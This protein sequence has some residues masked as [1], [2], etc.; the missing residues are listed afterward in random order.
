MGGKPIWR[1]SAGHQGQYSI[2]LTSLLYDLSMYPEPQQ[3]YPLEYKYHLLGKYT[4]P[5]KIQVNL[6]LY[7]AFYTQLNKSNVLFGGY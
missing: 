3:K 7:V 1:G 5:T 6:K 4:N 2:I